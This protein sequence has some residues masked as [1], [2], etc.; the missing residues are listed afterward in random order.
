MGTIF[1]SQRFVD[2]YNKE[3]LTGLQF[4]K[5]ES[6]YEEDK[7]ASIL[8]KTDDCG[9]IKSK[10]NMTLENKK[11]KKLIDGNSYYNKG[12]KFHIE[13]P[14]DWI[15][16]PQQWAGN[17]REKN[18]EMNHELKE[19]LSNAAVPF[20]S[21]YK[22]HNNPLYPYPTVQCSCR[23][24]G[25]FYRLNLSEI[26]EPLTNSFAQIYN[27]FIILEY[28]ADYIISGYRGIFIRGSFSINNLDGDSIECLCRMIIIDGHNFIYNIGLT[29]SKEAGEYQCE[30]EF[31]KIIKSIKI[32]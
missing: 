22:H 3:K 16:I 15:F 12:L 5:I 11:F 2:I 24:K 17:F 26:V 4:E 7:R 30:E 9:S 28:T 10:E 29:G 27:D 6:I 13:K 18:L 25:G 20:I 31:I 14:D 1:C 23:W 8:I 32:E 21:F 19:M